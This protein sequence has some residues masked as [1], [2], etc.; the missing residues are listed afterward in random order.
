[1]TGAYQPLLSMDVS[2][3][4]CDLQVE[5]LVKAYDS[6]TLG[7]VSLDVPRGSIVGLIGRNGAG[8]TTLMKCVLGTTHADAGTIR[9]FGEVQSGM[10]DRQLSAIKRRVAFVNSVTSYPGTMLISEVVG[11]YELAYPRFSRST[12]DALLG[13]LELRELSQPVRELSRGMGMKLQLACAFASGAELLVLDE[14]TSGLD[15]IVREEVLDA[16]REWMTDDSRSVL[17]SSHI[18]SD[19]GRLADYLV[20]ID[21]GRV[22]LSCAQDALEGLGVA[23]IR[24]AQLEQMR[25]SGGY[26]AGCIRVLRR[27]MSTDMLVTD[28]ESFARHYPDIACDRTDIDELMVFLAKGEVV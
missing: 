17:I 8:K 25:E 21:A 19:L 27:E 2:G 14:P 22:V 26:P 15:P 3:L 10:D 18:T 24:N 13:R 12:L 5:G 4:S 23:R 7:R 16:L 6:F 20:M 28:R 11:M 1:M 9:L